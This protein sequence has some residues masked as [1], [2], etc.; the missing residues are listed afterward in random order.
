MIGRLAPR[1]NEDWEMPG[2][3]PSKP[4]SVPDPSLLISSR[5][6]VVMGEARS[7]VVRPRGDALMITSG[8]ASVLVSSANAVWLVMP[9]A[10]IAD[11]VSIFVLKTCVIITPNR[12]KV[13][14]L[15]LRWSR[16]SE[17]GF[18]SIYRLGGPLK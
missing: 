6:S 14:L 2:W 9:M 8:A 3:L 18:R 7:I 13:S 11:V 5:V 12:V 4:P 16:S 1:A 17:V 15:L 10:T